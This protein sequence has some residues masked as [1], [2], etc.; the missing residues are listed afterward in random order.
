[1]LALPI[2]FLEP[3]G[4]SIPKMPS[5]DLVPNLQPARELLREPEPLI[6]VHAVLLLVAFLGNCRLRRRSL[7][8]VAARQYG[9]DVL[10]RRRRREGTA[11]EAARRGAGAPAAAPRRGALEVVGG[12]GAVEGEERRLLGGVV[13]NDVVVVVVRSGGREGFGCVGR[14]VGVPGGERVW[15]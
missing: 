2:A 13:G 6:Q 3:G 12:A 10:R 5:A 7:L 1:M 15:S 11:E 9:A 4:A 8:A 14:I